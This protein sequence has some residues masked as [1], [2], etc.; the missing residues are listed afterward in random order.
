MKKRCAK[1]ALRYIEEGMTVGL[2]GGATIGFLAEYLSQEKKN[3]RIVTPSAATQELC[4]KYGLTV[5]PTGT[6]DSVDIAFDGCDL[7][8]AQLNAVKSGGGIHTKEKLIAS[9]AKDYVLLVDDSKICE[10]FPEK[11]SITL[12]IIP[13]SVYYIKK[14]ITKLGGSMQVRSSS[15]K[16]GY[17]VS[18]HGNYIADAVFENVKDIRELD[19]ALCHLAGIVDTAVFI[20][21]A[22]FALCADEKEVRVIRPQSR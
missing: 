5:V 12:E 6:V 8:D 15:V 7:M 3:V 13:E 17:T 20:N 22:T 14:K 18:D 16:A 4:V 11:L 2:G 19:E 9:M 10:A 1:E 21:K